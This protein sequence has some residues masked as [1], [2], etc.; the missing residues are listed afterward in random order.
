M[1]NGVGGLLYAHKQGIDLV[2]GRAIDTILRK[3]VKITDAI[4]TAMLMEQ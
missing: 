2:Q 4:R 1:I 3:G